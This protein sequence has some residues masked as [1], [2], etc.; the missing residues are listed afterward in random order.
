MRGN[1]G[2]RET[3]WYFLDL[4]TM[5]LRRLFESSKD[6]WEE[7]FRISKDRFHLRKT[8]NIRWRLFDFYLRRYIITN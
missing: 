8:D 5:S 3:W 1:Y 4:Y 2:T 6:S 7:I